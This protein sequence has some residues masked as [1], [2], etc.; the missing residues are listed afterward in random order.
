MEM[1]WNRCRWSCWQSFLIREEW[2]CSWSFCGTLGS[3][4]KKIVFL[5]FTVNEKMQPAW[6]MKRKQDRVIKSGAREC[7]SDPMHYFASYVT[8]NVNLVFSYNKLTCHWMLFFGNTSLCDST[9]IFH[10]SK[11]PSSNPSASDNLIN[12]M[13]AS[14]MKYYGMQQSLNS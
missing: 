1:F 9:S 13:T 14:C 8:W 7:R 11:D 12:L 2:S 3:W 6:G 4:L 5:R 10:S